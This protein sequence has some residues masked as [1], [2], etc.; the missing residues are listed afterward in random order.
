MTANRRGPIADA[1]SG[2]FGRRVTDDRFGSGNASAEGETTANSQGH[3]DAESL[4]ARKLSAL[5][6]ANEPELDAPP[7]APP[8][9]EPGSEPPPK[10]VRVSRILD[11]AGMLFAL[12]LGWIGYQSLAALPNRTG[13]SPWALV[14][15]ARTPEEGPQSSADQ[16]KSPTTEPASAVEPLG[17]FDF[18]PPYTPSMS[19]DHV[20]RQ[21][22]QAVENPQWETGVGQNASIRDLEAAFNA[23]YI[24]PPECSDWASQEQMVSCGNHRMRALRE[25]VRS[26][27]KMNQAMLGAPIDAVQGEQQQRGDRTSPP[28]PQGPDTWREEASQLDQWG[29]GQSVDPDQYSG[30]PSNYGGAYPDHPQSHPND[31]GSLTWRQEQARRNQQNG[32]GDQGAADQQSW[33]SPQDWRLRYRQDTRPILRAGDGGSASSWQDW[34]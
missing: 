3:G 22:V 18:G 32:Q 20:N 2:I 24:P 4:L 10:R 31:Q 7:V 34:Q 15:T 11:A 16:S 27:G 29:Q 19:A 5:I 17:E 23:N 25:F 9:E 28:A 21:E 1:N 26:G 14:G 8:T 6:R 12:G 13:E 33:G 30:S